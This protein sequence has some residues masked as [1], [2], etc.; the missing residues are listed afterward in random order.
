MSLGIQ[1]SIS[2]MR[3]WERFLES[4]DCESDTLFRPRIPFIANPCAQEE[5][6]RRAKARRF[7]QVAELTDLPEM[8]SRK[9]AFFRSRCPCG[10]A[11]FAAACPFHGTQEQGWARERTSRNQAE[12][13]VHCRSV[14]QRCVRFRVCEFSAA[15]WSASFEDM[16]PPLSG[17]PQPSCIALVL[18]GSVDVL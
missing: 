8:A 11:G 4:T 14:T 12:C 15:A 1:V 3:E 2:K 5:C 9:R 16:L 10:T 17:P 18:C 6:I 7:S 13:K